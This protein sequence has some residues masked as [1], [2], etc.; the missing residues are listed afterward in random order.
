MDLS[1][2]FSIADPPMEIVYAD[3]SSGNNVPPKVALGALWSSSDGSSLYQ[4]FGEFSDT[5]A[6]TP[7]T[8]QMWQFHISS[9]AWSGQTLPQGMVRPAEG[10]VALA[11]GA[12]SN[13]QPMAYYFGGHIDECVRFELPVC[14]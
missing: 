4:S 7:T 3:H 9:N 2:S 11:P 1:S 14:P 5:P 13:G 12:G 8:N 6:A 10:A